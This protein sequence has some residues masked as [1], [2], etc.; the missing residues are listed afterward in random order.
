L[1]RRRCKCWAERS[2]LG[3]CFAPRGV[4][5]WVPPWAERGHAARAGWPAETNG[6]SL[7]V[8]NTGIGVTPEQQAK[9]FGEFCPGRGLDG[10]VLGR[11]RPRPRDPARGA[12]T[13]S[14]HRVYSSLSRS[15]KVMGCRSISSTIVRW[16]QSSTLLSAACR[17][18]FSLKNWFVTQTFLKRIP[19]WRA[20]YAASPATTSLIASHPRLPSTVEL[21]HWISSPF[22]PIATTSTPSS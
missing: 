11:Y 19:G 21:L 13:A 2:I 22:E 5:A 1:S 9:L 12:Y 10:A 4:L 18:A 14:S 16:S 15:N 6:S 17:R 7:A 8:A 3:P 20:R